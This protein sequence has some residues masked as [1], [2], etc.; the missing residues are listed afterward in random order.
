M[1]RRLTIL[2]ALAAAVVAGVASASAI[3]AQVSPDTA[4]SPADVQ[5]D[6]SGASVPVTTADP[7]GRPAYA[8]RVYRS[9][10]GLTCPEVGHSEDGRFGQL[11]ASGEVEAYG[12]EATGACSD[13]AKGPLGIAINHY[14]A[15]GKLPARAV[16]FGVTTDAI[17]S[18]RLFTPAAGGE[19]PVRFA[20]NTYIAVVREDA[21]D[22]ASLDVTLTDGSTKSYPLAPSSAPQTA[23]PP[24]AEETSTQ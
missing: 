15:R 1:R 19:R 21:L 16:V 2:L 12:V 11:D 10:S 14:P 5:P 20:G 8:V 22:G 6:G 9:K 24:P 18:V 23:P 4:V 13:L 17:A 3:T 7:D